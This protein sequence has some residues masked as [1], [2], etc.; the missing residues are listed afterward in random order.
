MFLLLGA[1]HGTLFPFPS[2]AC[3]DPTFRLAEGVEVRL[4]LLRYGLR[5]TER[6][7]L[8][9]TECL[10]PLPSSFLFFVILILEPLLLPISE[11]TSINLGSC[12]LFRPSTPF[13]GPG[14]FP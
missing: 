13:R 6:L 10:I 2:S 12:S 14:C 5:L 7:G 4:F 1:N 9:R 8:S 3:Q 11:T